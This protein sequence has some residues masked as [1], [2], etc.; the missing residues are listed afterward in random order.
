[1]SFLLLIVKIVIHTVSF[2]Y[3]KKKGKGVR[4]AS[5]FALLNQIFQ[6]YSVFWLKL[7]QILD[8]SHDILK[9]TLCLSNLD[10]W[11]KGK[12]EEKA[13]QVLYFEQLTSA[14]RLMIFAGFE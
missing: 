4:K 12:G 10:T 7:F 11:I 2:P 6:E 14:R 13:L 9:L 8:P 3:F 1:M 5:K